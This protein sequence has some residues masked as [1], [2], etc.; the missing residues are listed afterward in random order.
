M[1]NEHIMLS[2]SRRSILKAKRSFS[3]HAVV[4]WLYLGDDFLKRR[5]VAQRLGGRFKLLDITKLHDDVAKDIKHEH[6][7]W[8]DKLNRHYGDKLEWWFGSV[9][10]RNIYD[11]KLFQYCCY[12]EIL[13]RIQENQDSSLDLI[14]VESAGLAKAVSKWA[15]KSG[16]KM[17]VICSHTEKL[18]VS[19]QLLRTFVSWTKFLILILSRCAAAY[20]T[21]IR[22]KK[23]RISLDTNVL[24]NTTIHDYSLSDDG[25]FNDRYFPHLH[26]CMQEKGIK[27]VI[28][29]FVYGFRY[30]YFSIYQRM[31]L[32]DTKFIIQ[33]DFLRFKDYVIALTYPLRAFRQNIESV[34]FRGFDLSDVL[35]EE[36]RTRSSISGFEPV[37]I[38]RLLLRL[39]DAGLKL[40]SILTWYENRTIDRA[41]I[42]GARRAFPMVK[43]TGAQIFLHSPNFLSLYPSQSEVEANITPD[44]LLE[45][46]Q[47]QCDVAQSFTG[48]IPCKP[49]AALRYSHV[50]NNEDVF[51]DDGGHKTRSILILL[52]FNINK[53]VELLTTLKVAFN[54]IESDIR[55]LIK[56]HPDYE[57]TTLIRTFGEKEWPTRFGIFKG[58]L[59]H[60]LDNVSMVISASSSAMV[61]TA[62]K[63]IPAI[64]VGGQTVLDQNILFDLDMDIVTECFSVSEVVAAINQYLEVSPDKALEYREAGKK[65]RD[66]YFK[67]VNEETMLPFLEVA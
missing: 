7:E 14:V 1:L 66:L 44:R 26:E 38:Y 11:S 10:S 54:E 2:F 39:K 4:H 56:G 40:K 35:K 34:F 63:G 59:S 53:A 19:L 13:N 15:V 24:V 23:G 51:V 45:T 12:L 41:F 60:S 33:E 32:S 17:N 8:I 36:Q 28:A 30:N 9:S 22:Y 61:E 20:L 48:S 42:A 31:R 64:F 67:P 50:F 16:I 55:I 47:H 43:I 65:L 49:A 6:V 18:G 57:L 37:L 27:T 58:E 21:R 25:I 29:P 46:S 62:I 52:P 5:F 3:G